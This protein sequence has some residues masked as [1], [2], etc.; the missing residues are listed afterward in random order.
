[1]TYPISNQVYPVANAITGTKVFITVF[2]TRNPTTTDINYQPTQK[3]FNTANNEYWI[4]VNFTVINGVTTANWHP[5]SSSLTLE[6]LTGN[7]GIS[8]GPDGSDN[9][10][11]LG[12][13]ATGINITGNAATHTLTVH[14]LNGNPTVGNTVDT[15]TGPGT[16]PVLPNAAGL[17]TV[18]GGQ[19][20]AGTTAHVIQTDSLA[21]NT[22]TIQIQR[23]QAV[24]AST[25]GDNGVSHFNSAQFSVDSNGF[26]SLLAA[27]DLHVTPF[28]VSAAGSANGANFTTIQAAV[29]A[30]NTA[31]GGIVV[32]QP[33][34]Y[35]ENLTLFSNVHIM[36]LQ[37]A[38]AGG[39]VNIVGT[40]TPPTSGGVAIQYVAMTGTAAIFNSAAAGS[41]HLVLANAAITVTNGYTFNLPNWTGKLESFDVNAAIGTADGYVNNSGG[42]TIAIFDSS[43]G[44]GTI[45]VMTISGSYFA[46]GIA[47]F[48]PIN[49]ITGASISSDF[50][51]YSATVT[52]SNNSTGYFRNN[53]FTGN[54]LAAITMSSSSAI[55]LSHAVVSSTNNPAIAGA[56]A[57]TL[58]YTDVNFLFNSAFA[59]TL[60]L[61]TVSWR[62]YSQAIASTN[63]TKVGTAAFNS[64]QFTVDTNG[65]VSLVGGS[66]PSIE[67]VV[68][69]AFTGPGTNPVL[70]NGSGEIIV[71][72]G[73]VAAGTTANVIRTDSLA[74][75]TYTIQVQRSQ[76]V[77]SS[78]VG[79]N[80]VAH[81]NSAQFSVDSNGFVSAL[82]NAINYTNVNHA[83][84][85][86][87][88]LATDYYISVDCSAGTVQLNFPNAPTFKQ[89]W[90]IKDRT[91]NA[92]TNNI[93]LTTPGG[94]VTFD[95]LTTYT[96]N[97]NYQSTQLLANATPT[98]E[99]Y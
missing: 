5:I 3:W 75:N 33:G 47:I 14:G 49:F 39:G 34:T 69:D 11:V 13:N 28:I 52:L 65:F 62:P 79:D 21:A 64:A 82:G 1:M 85:P 27:D 58:T 15:F 60:T 59:G 92:A 8:V 84:S 24:A 67:S 71:T 20:A 72:G 43:V 93:T 19:V 83:A 57:G 4:L 30:A 74:A 50:N 54:S 81:F 18:T 7:D 94:A 76:A 86:Y 89:E 55:E 77:A 88:V 36:G 12:D 91:G 78:T 66:G 35:T 99:V 98:Y 10:F 48:C 95:G 17:I 6:T 96:M 97:S 2:S 37:L 22:Y 73:Q 40:H 45:N 68:V 41:T 38:D 31:G 25:I 16:D 26:V 32:V 87:T 9:I 51:T 90:I 56:G 23:S 53:T 61:A 29:N 46:D 70:P 44:S 63:G 42:A 80:G